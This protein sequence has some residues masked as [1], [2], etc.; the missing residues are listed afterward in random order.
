MWGGGGGGG[1]GCKAYLGDDFG[2]QGWGC[3]AYLGGDSG[4]Q[5]WGIDEDIQVAG[6]GHACRW[7]QVEVGHESQKLDVV[8]M[9]GMGQTRQQ[10]NEAT[11]TITPGS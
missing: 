9:V 4:A 11:G 5:G 2:A 8:G 10:G 7:I 1:G 3:T 6:I